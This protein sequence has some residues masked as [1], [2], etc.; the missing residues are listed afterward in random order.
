MHFQTCA[1]GEDDADQREGTRTSTV[2]LSPAISTTPTPL[3]PS[4]AWGAYRCVPLQ[5]ELLLRGVLSCTL[6]AAPRPDIKNF[7]LLLRSDPARCGAS[8]S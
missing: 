5:I 3:R 7:L 1:L 8:C 6:V 4:Q 2:R